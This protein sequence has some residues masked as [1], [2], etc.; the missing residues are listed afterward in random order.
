ML[1]FRRGHD[2]TAKD[3][4]FSSGSIVWECIYWPVVRTMR[5]RALPCIMR[6]YASAA[7]SEEGSRS[8]GG[9]FQNLNASVSS[10]SIAVPVSDP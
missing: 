5:N 7:C 9:Y 8:L 6:A 10:L 3:F 4:D 1:R 2:R